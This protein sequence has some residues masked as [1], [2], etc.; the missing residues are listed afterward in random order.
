MPTID[1]LVLEIESNSTQ[2]ESGLDSMAKALERLRTATSNQRGLN[3]VAKGIRA[4]AD[5]TNA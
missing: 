3:V 1:N 5:S 2:A 4:V